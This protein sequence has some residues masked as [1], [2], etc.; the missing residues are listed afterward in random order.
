MKIYIQERDRRDGVFVATTEQG[1]SICESRTPI[2]D[3]AR[4]LAGMGVGDAEI[5]HTYRR[6]GDLYPSATCT[7]GWAKKRTVAEPKQTSGLYFSRYVKNP[8]EVVL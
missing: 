7:I 3:A 5:L 4:F 1:V 8:F 2:L 6:R